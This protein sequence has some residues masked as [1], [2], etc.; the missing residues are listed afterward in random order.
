MFLF[1]FTV[2]VPNAKE[3]LWNTNFRNF[4]ETEELS[5][6]SKEL[7]TTLTFRLL[8]GEIRHFAGSHTVFITFSGHYC[9]HSLREGMFFRLK[10]EFIVDNSV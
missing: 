1:L 5:F 8:F 2:Y 7:I 9:H 10:H 3:A 6:L 4:I